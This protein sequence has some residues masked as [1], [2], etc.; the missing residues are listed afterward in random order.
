[1]HELDGCGDG[2]ERRLCDFRE[3]A[4]R[5]HEQRP[6]SFAAAEHRVAHR[7]KQSLGHLLID[8][9]NVGEFLIDSG[10]VVIETLGERRRCSPCY[11]RGPS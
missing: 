1:M 10:A 9:E 8:V 2:I 4:A 7:R 5:I 11:H 6:H 3:L